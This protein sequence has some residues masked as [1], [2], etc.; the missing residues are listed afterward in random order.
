MPS[1]LPATLG[2]LP[3]EGGTGIPVKPNGVHP[4]RSIVWVA[5]EATVKLW[6]GGHSVL[7]PACAGLAPRASISR[8]SK[9]KSFVELGCTL[10]C[11]PDCKPTP[12]TPAPMICCR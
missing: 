5:P 2:I 4:D 11:K 12:P 9:P 3:C 10:D 8:H 7:G 6:L 1:P